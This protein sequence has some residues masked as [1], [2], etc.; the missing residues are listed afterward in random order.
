MRKIFI[1]F[2]TLIAISCQQSSLQ[3]GVDMVPQPQEITESKGSIKLD[4]SY[5]ITWSSK[6]SAMLGEQLSKTI[7]LA[8]GVKLKTEAN[9]SSDNKII[10]GLDSSIEDEKYN[11]SVDS[12]IT[13]NAGN[14]QTL[15]LASSSIVQMIKVIDGELYCSKVN[16]TDY[17]SYEWRTVM[18]DLARFWHPMESIKELVVMLQ[19][20]K[21]PNLHLHMTDNR[22]VTFGTE[23]FPEL[24]IKN[25]DGSNRYYTKS[26]LKDLVEFARLR[27]VTIIPEV[28]LP[29]HS[30]RFISDNGGA[31]TFGSID[32]NGKSRSIGVV[33]MADESCYIALEKLIGEIAEVFTTSPYIHIGGDEVWLDGIKNIPEYKSFCLDHD[34]KEA[35]EGKAEELYAYF[36]VRMDSVVRKLGKKTIFWEGFHGDGAGRIKI[37]N[38]IPI[39]VWNGNY[40]HP[41]ALLDNGYSVVNAMWVPNYMCRAMN[42]A[43]TQEQG[44]N[45]THNI[46]NHWDSAIDDIALDKSAEIKGG[47]ICFWEQNYNVIVP[48]LR[49]RVPAQ[50]DRWWN[51]NSGDSYDQFK[52]RFDSVD[53]KLI[54]I[55]R[56]VTVSA[57]GLTAAGELNF[58]SSIDIKLESSVPGTIKYSIDKEWGDMTTTDG[59]KFTA[60]F[61]LKESGVIT[62][63][64]Y[65]NS[66]SKIGY[67]TQI[68]YNRIEPILR[69]KAFGGSPHKGW[70]SMPSF[71]SLPLIKEGVFGKVD[72]DRMKHIQREIFYHIE[73]K[74]HIDTRPSGLSNPFA[75]RMDGSVTIP[76]SGEWKFIITGQDGLVNITIGDQT[77]KSE[78]VD[79]KKEEFTLDLTEGVH[80]IE[81][82]YYYRFIQNVLNVKCIAPGSD[83]E[84]AFE[85]LI[86]SLD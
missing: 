4:E 84:I 32:K 55:L 44:Y 26:E 64:L 42:F 23:L 31:K 12:D 14:Y 60:S 83:K 57:T 38:D 75:L 52:A 13:L 6:E 15:A 54:K 37:P 53:E 51:Y 86:D 20:Y 10:L 24:L 3:V 34:L 9:S 36:L 67:P 27:G 7:Y 35:A 48:I 59:T 82:D 16:I 29:G 66:G 61:K 77:I 45:W 1:L 71:E 25:A 69:Y 63:Q 73:H 21:I 72:N 80:S 11:L 65:D 22:S 2:I 79:F 50:S 85:E 46:F 19:Y 41:Q 18:I 5:V 28:D 49:S 30:G 33:N 78:T 43:P 17:P 68:R 70:E 47:Q 40:N 58:T 8:T 76:K 81:I 62:A 56:P 74:G 39:V